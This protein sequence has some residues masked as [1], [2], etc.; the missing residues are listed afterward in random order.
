MAA[1]GSESKSIIT[2]KILETFQDSFL[3]DKEIRIPIKEGSE[4]IQIKCT[5]TAA[6]TNVEAGGDTATPAESTVKIAGNGN[7]DI[8]PEEKAEVVDLVTRLGL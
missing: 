5:L 7:T 8:T 4:I 6:K 2:K 1:R 3:Y